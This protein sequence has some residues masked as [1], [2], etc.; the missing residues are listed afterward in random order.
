MTD[1]RICLAAAAATTLAGTALL[2]IIDGTTWV[3]SG[4]AA[5]LLIMAVGLALRRLGAPGVLLIPVQVLTFFWLFTIIFAAD[6]ALLGVLPSPASTQK[7]IQLLSSGTDTLG[8]FA[9]PVPDDTG[10]VLIVCLALAMVGILVDALAVTLN[11]PTAAGLPLLALYCVPSA[12]LE[13]ELP[14]WFFLLG[15]LGWLLLLALGTQ[16]YLAGWGQ[17]LP[18]RSSGRAAPGRFLAVLALVFAVFIPPLVPTIGDGQLFGKS[19]GDST[20]FAERTSINP[21]LQLREDLKPRRDIEVLRYRTNDPQPPPLR[22]HVI[23]NFDGDPWYADSPYPNPDQQ[24]KNGFPVPPGLAAAVPRSEYSMDVEALGVLQL[25]EL[26]VPYPATKVTGESAWLFDEK[27]LTVIGEGIP[28]RRQKYQVKYAA[29]RPTVGQLSKTATALPDNFLDVER[30]SVYLSPEFANQAQRITRGAKN[31]YDQAVALQSWFQKDGG[32]SYSV[33][34]PAEGSTDAIDSFLRDRSGY[35]VQF[36]A[37]MAVLARSLGIPSRVALG[38]LPGE[39]K[40]NGWYS[41]RLTDAHAWPEL[42]LS[43]LGWVRFEPTPGSRAGSGPQY[44]PRPSASSPTTAASESRSQTATARAST[45]SAS[46]EPAAKPKTVSVR[47]S[48]A[49]WWRTALPALA[50]LLVLTFCLGPLLAWRQRRRLARLDWLA[51]VAQLWLELHA[52]LADLGYVL[53]PSATVRQQAARVSELGDLAES[54]EE[55]LVQLIAAVEAAHYGR[56]APATAAREM[57]IPELA[58]TVRI[59]VAQVAQRSPR[60]MRWRATLRP[61]SGWGRLGLAVR[62]ASRPLGR[63]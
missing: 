44:S 34:G 60:R 47:S 51:A 43:G 33:K 21:I 56:A 18:T 4:L 11:S 12:V 61:V 42:F 54:D 30:Q 39:K 46:A 36:S 2:P 25:R 35:C 3:F 20:E 31:P 17:V 41:V 55:L 10:V 15:M 40:S 28:T 26:P 8:R 24:T 48:P 13:P 5:L 6:S 22:T 53:D 62:W 1:L 7:L 32:F 57:A 16:N 19:L 58:D 37:A 14:A 29:I 9:A 38:F 49:T 52:R 27:S 59:I 50:V 23:R 63:R 45:T